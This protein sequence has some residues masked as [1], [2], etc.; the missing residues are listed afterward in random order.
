MTCREMNKA[1]MD[2]LGM[3][4]VPRKRKKQ[5]KRIYKKYYGFTWLKCDNMVLFYHWAFKNPFHIDIYLKLHK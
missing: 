3:R 5:L 2:Y 4:R 1:A